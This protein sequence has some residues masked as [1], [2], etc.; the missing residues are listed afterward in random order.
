MSDQPKLLKIL[1]GTLLAMIVAVTALLFSPFTS[2]VQ[3]WLALEVNAHINELMTSPTNALM[4][5]PESIAGT[6]SAA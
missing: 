2:E 4:S 1:T 5:A 3:D 6:P